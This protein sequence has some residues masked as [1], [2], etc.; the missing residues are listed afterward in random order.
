MVNAP[1]NNRDFVARCF[2]N[3]PC[4][5]NARDSITNNDDRFF[6]V[7]ITHI[8]KVQFLVRKN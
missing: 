3:V 2:S 4:R 6:G 1:R 8:A 5:S 7:I